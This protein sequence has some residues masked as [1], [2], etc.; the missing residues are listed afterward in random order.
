MDSLPFTDST[1]H[2]DCSKTKLHDIPDQDIKSDESTKD[3][4]CNNVIDNKKAQD[5]VSS[6]K[7]E[8]I[9]KMKHI[10]QYVTPPVAVVSSGL[11]VKGEFK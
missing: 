2:D 1:S 8:T 10:K 3:P 7:N 9:A 6:G 4:E 11:I 5:V